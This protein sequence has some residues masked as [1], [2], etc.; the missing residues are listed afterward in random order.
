MSFFDNN[1]PRLEQVYLADYNGKLL[2]NFNP[3]NSRITDYFKINQLAPLLN[4]ELL[5]TA[6][7]IPT[8][9]KYDID[10][11]IT[12]M[13][14]KNLFSSIDLNIKARPNLMLIWT[15]KMILAIVASI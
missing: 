4:N 14:M 5:T 12:R 2:Y 7:H 6:T 1:L 8:K 10:N 3:I 15:F 9:Y 13:Q 11:E